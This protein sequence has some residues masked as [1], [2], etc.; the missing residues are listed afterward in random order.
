MMTFC[1]RQHQRGFTLAELVVVGFSLVLLTLL[2]VPALAAAKRKAHKIQ[3]TNNLMQLGMAFRIWEGDHNNI[4]P[5][6][7]V[8]SNSPPEKV[9]VDTTTEAMFQMMSNELCT[10]IILVCPADDLCKPASGF[11]IPLASSN[12]SFFVNMDAREMNPQAPLSGDDNFVLGGAPIE[13][14]IWEI[15]SNTPIAWSASRHRLRGN[16][17]LAD[18]SVSSTDNRTLKSWFEGTN[19]APIRLSIP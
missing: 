17:A 1:R 15:A 8:V 14:G 5:M 12:I 7:F 4:Y 18:G 9:P 19:S 10:P 11:K 2:F 3:C 6:D 16:V 13:S